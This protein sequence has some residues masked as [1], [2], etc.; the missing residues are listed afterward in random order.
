MMFSSRPGSRPGLFLFVRVY[1][2]LL[3]TC[4]LFI[5]DYESMSQK[6]YTTGEAAQQWV[7]RE[8]LCKY[9]SRL[10]RLPPRRRDFVTALG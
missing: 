6:L 9:G 1:H 7:S 2:H 8:Q 5:G 4:T 10:A 3:D